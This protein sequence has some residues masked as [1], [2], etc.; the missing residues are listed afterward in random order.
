M[1]FTKFLVCLQLFTL[2]VFIIGCSDDDSKDNTAPIMSIKTPVNDALYSRGQSIILNADFT[3][4]KDLLQV[5]ATIRAVP[6]NKGIDTP[7]EATETISLTGKK[8][9]LSSHALF[10]A[11]IPYD[12]MSGNY[13]IEFVVADKA[14]NQKKNFIPITIE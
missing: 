6:T 12:I 8:H 13:H 7:W 5:T 9:N 10:N 3:D 11:S 1:R 2:S 4:D 14:N